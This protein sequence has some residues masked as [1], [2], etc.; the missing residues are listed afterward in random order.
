M[1]SDPTALCLELIEDRGQTELRELLA[2]LGDDP[3]FDYAIASV[4]SLLLPADR[5]R[6]LGAY[7]T[8]PHLVDH[9]LLRLVQAG[10]DPIVQGFHDPA[11]G[12]AAFI[13]PLVRFLLGHPRLANLPAPELLAILKR[14]LSGQELDEG[15]ACIANG[16]IRR[17]LRDHGIECP[18]SFRLVRVGDSL[19]SGRAR[20]YEVIVGNPPYRKVGRDDH[21]QYATA[22]PDILGGQLNLYALFMRNSVG[23]LPA[24]GVLGFIVPTSF[25][26]GPDFRRLRISLV[27]HADLI[28][29]DLI[30][31]RAGTFL[32]VIQDTCVVVMRRRETGRAPGLDPVSCARLR[33]DGNLQAIGEML[34]T[35]DGE[36]WMLPAASD[37]G[38]GGF[39]LAEYGYR[40]R[41]GTIVANRQRDQLRETCEPGCWPLVDARCIRSDG[42]FE[43]GSGRYPYVRV[44]TGAPGVFD[45]V[46]AVVQR[47]INRKQ[48][49]RINAAAVPAAIVCRFGGLVGENHV[50]L[51]VSDERPLL[52]SNSLARLLNSRAVNSKYDRLCG[53]VSVSAHLLSSIDLPDPTFLDALETCTPEDVD[54]VVERA[55]GA[56]NSASTKP[57]FESLVTRDRFTAPFD[58]AVH[59]TPGK[60]PAS[61]TDGSKM[62]G[63]D[64]HHSS[65]LPNSAACSGP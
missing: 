29:L 11:A 39:T 16:L 15:L 42:S 22:F 14:H 54:E 45:K 35:I 12:G 24:G 2:Y 27:E 21:R 43:H 52:P 58:R 59:S 1:T 63:R 48:K 51:V 44:S 60:D 57:E 37:L 47:T 65:V 36:P 40:C 31:K 61:T 17:A 25:L 62:P 55:Y 34:P 5:R 9:L 26:A 41:V 30:E 50:I 4:Y 64:G 13:V 56:T 32:D 53:T 49:R 38:T 8:P 6:T 28:A 33:S 3:W 23:R 46:A 18:A 19:G 10:V 7:F 20:P